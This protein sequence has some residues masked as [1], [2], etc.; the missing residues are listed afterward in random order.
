MEHKNSMASWKKSGLVELDPKGKDNRRGYD[1]ISVS[2]R[3]VTQYLEG[4]ISTSVDIKILVDYRLSTQ[5]ELLV[6]MAE[7]FCSKSGKCKCF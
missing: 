2:D 7:V 3:T 5:F 4:H 1:G 6:F